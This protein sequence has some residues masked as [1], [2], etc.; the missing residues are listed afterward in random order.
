MTN[1]CIID[2]LFRQGCFLRSKY[3]FFF[4]L[5]TQ[6]REICQFLIRQTSL[7]KD[8]SHSSIPGVLYIPGLTVSDPFTDGRLPHC[9]TSLLTRSIS[10]MPREAGG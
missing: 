8:Y 4:W 6:K 3:S 1:R 9:F 7:N 2:R 10:V 5:F